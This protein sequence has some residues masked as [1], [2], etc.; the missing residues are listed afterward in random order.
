MKNYTYKGYEPKNFDEVINLMLSN[1]YA[2]RSKELDSFRG[3]LIKTENGYTLKVHL[4]G[5]DFKA[6]FTYETELGNR[7]T[8]KVKSIIEK[9]MDDIIDD[10]IGKDYR[11]TYTETLGDI[12]DEPVVLAKKEWIG[13]YADFE[14]FKDNFELTAKIHK[15]LTPN[16]NECQVML[17]DDPNDSTKVID[18]QK[19]LVTSYYYGD[20]KWNRIVK[21]I[22][23]EKL[24]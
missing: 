21:K 13:S 14:A 22:V 12:Y 24:V 5:N 17:R 10:Y 3:F 19:C 2:I 11:L 18:N 1:N 23:C 9:V 8:K 6:Y 4:I 15:D 20:Y 16:A 7:L